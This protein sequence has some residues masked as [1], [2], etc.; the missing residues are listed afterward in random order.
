MKYMIFNI[1]AFYLIKKIN[2]DLINSLTDLNAKAAA[3]YIIGEFCEQ[4]PESTVIVT[5][6]VNNFSNVELNSMLYFYIFSLNLLL[7]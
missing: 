3:L 5:Y 1:R 7:L 4:I 2:L 6:F